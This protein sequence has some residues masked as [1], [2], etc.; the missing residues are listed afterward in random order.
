[1]TAPL[2]V[3]NVSK[4]FGGSPALHDVGFDAEPGE[5]LGLIGPNG[6]GK[7][8]L[9][10]CLAG[11][12]SA[13]SGDVRF[14]GRALPPGRRKEALFYVPDGIAPWPDQPLGAALSFF[15]ALN[16]SRRLVGDLVDALGLAAHVGQRM[17]A[18]SKGQTKR[19]LLALGLLTPQP[20]LLVDEPF[21]GLDLRQARE[22]MSLLREEKTRRGRTLVLSI[23][24]LA[25]AARVC[26]RFVLLSNGRV[27]GEGDLVALRGTA[28]ALSD[29]LEE[30]FLALT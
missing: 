30:I 29:S 7:T 1:M 22:V 10:E 6:S 25:D 23:H 11:L 4:R 28:G 17:G 18:L 14:H 24:Q 16:S 21:D 9:F 12:L 19:A 26:D 8:T 2:A 15:S 27:A 5:V 3:R 20:V 13:D